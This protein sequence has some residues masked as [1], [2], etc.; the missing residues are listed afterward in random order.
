MAELWG[1][2]LSAVK[3]VELIP[4]LVKSI[5][6]RLS[7]PEFFE[8]LTSEGQSALSDLAQNQG[9]IPWSVFTRQYGKLREMG[10]ARR[11]R[12]KPFLSPISST[13][14][15]WYRGILFRIFQETPQGSEE[16][17][18]I[19]QEVISII[20]RIKK[21]QDSLP[22]RPAL[23][24][25]CRMQFLVND[26]ILD[27]TCTLLA[28][29]RLEYNRQQLDAIAEEW[30]GKIPATIEQPY[31]TPSISSLIACLRSASLL[32]EK[33]I[34]NPES[35]RTFLEASRAEAVTQLYQA[36][37]SS[38][39][40]N[41]LRMVS[42]LAFEG[43]WQ[44]DPRE[45]RRAVLSYLMAVPPKTWWS[46][47]A[48]IDFIYQQNPD[49]QRR[50]GEYDTWYIRQ[51]STNASLR[52]FDHWNDVEGALIRFILTA[53]LHWMGVLDLASAEETSAI[54]AFRITPWGQSLLSGHIPVGF[55]EE[56]EHIYAYADGR[57]RIPV[58]APRAARYQISRFCRWEHKKTAE[59]HYRITPESLDLAI[60]QGLHIPQLQ[61]L[62]QRYASGIPPILVTALSR[63]E[64]HGCEARLEH[65][66]VLR[67]RDAELIKKL[68]ESKVARFLGDSLGATSIIIKPGGWEKVQ[69]FL[70]EL[71]YLSKS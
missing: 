29:L 25:E 59:Y 70:A 67:V 8:T 19:P 47:P 17:A 28:A 26:S 60:R 11:D 57:L 33:D 51:A 49:F 54:L 53:P 64:N 24:D 40:Y 6:E 42:S 22:G 13:E 1:I 32:G 3:D 45:A 10:A 69:S 41:D 52:G 31:T 56:N 23:S 5:L 37:V 63:W 48:F 68:K 21:P 38:S 46:L 15:L 14:V 43:N 36:W 4:F 27:H 50:G 58:L 62:L 18:Y 35:T 12:E 34:P 16:F 71:G 65:V 61:S 44:N 66:A 9:A 2:N 55:K 7:N 30:L 39:Q 20:P